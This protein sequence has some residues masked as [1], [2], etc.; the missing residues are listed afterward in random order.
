MNVSELELIVRRQQVEIES[1]KGKINDIYNW[2]ND[3]NGWRNDALGKHAE[4]RQLFKQIGVE[5]AE[6]A[7]KK[8]KKQQ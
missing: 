2:M 4:C 3:V 8:P 5:L 7:R 6:S 1:L